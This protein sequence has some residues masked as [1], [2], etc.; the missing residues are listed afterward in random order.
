MAGKVIGLKTGEAVT[1]GRA[2]GRAQFALPHDTFMSGVH[3]AVECGTSG[4]R[5]QDRKSSNGTFLNGARIQDAM[6]ANGDEIKGGQTIFA[7]KIVADAKLASLMPAQEATPSSAPQPRAPV[8]ASSPPQSHPRAVE[9][10]PPATPQQRPPA[11]EPLPPSAPELRPRAA[12]A[13]PLP[14]RP[15]RPAGAESA[16]PSAPLPRPRAVEP[17]PPS[18]LGSRPLATEPEPPLVSPSARNPEEPKPAPLRGTPEVQPPRGPIA[19]P[20]PQSPVM[21]TGDVDDAADVRP[22]RDA[23]VEPTGGKS[24]GVPSLPAQGLPRKIEAPFKSALPSVEEPPRLR[25]IP[26]PPRGVEN[27]PGAGVKPPGS[28]EPP[29]GVA[30]HIAQKFAERPASRGVG[31]SRGAAFSVMGWSFP[32]APAEWLV[33]EGFGLQQSGHEEFPSSVAAT[34]ELL[35]GITLQQF[36]ESQISTLRGYL[37]D[38]KIEPTMPPRVGGADESMAVDVRHSTKDGRELVYR[39]IYARSGSSVGVLTVTTLAADFPQVLQSLQPL[40][41]GAAFRSTTNN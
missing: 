15:S 11:A 32:A 33:Q 21:P 12:D 35:G 20:V 7:V 24:S 25:A 40:L 31:S 13:A 5:V 3:F 39:R 38:P 34:E 41:D 18:A 23:G 17:A 14:A 22:A 10:A 2:A 16:L 36:V 9:S 26:S 28:G 29:A 6:L 19:E 30:P 1:V 8:D 37:R 4:C 27:S